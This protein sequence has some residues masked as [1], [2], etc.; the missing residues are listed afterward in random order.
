MKTEPIN[1]IAVW[2]DKYSCVENYCSGKTP[3]WRG[4]KTWK[5]KSGLISL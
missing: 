5:R 3:K 1:M 4:E 2:F